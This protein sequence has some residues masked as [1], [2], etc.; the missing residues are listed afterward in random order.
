MRKIFLVECEIVDTMSKVSD[1]VTAF[2][3]E[4]KAKE[5]YN[6]IVE[7]IKVA[8]KSTFE[9]WEEEESENSI[10]WY[11]NGS[12]L[13]DHIDVSIREVDLH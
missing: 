6:D 3:S 9:C 4:E 2:E 10:S 1:E 12:Y 11:P 5:F 8:N 7:K 13:D